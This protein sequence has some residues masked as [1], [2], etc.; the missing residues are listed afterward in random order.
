M[1]LSDV[2]LSDSAAPP[3][4]EL[5]NFSFFF[6]DV[7]GCLFRRRNNHLSDGPCVVLSDAVRGRR[8]SILF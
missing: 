8:C 3:R 5:Q 2:V 7:L 1:L 6:A 4:D